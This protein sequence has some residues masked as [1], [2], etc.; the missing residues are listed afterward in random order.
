MSRHLGLK[1]GQQC[2][3]LVR[4]ERS[5]QVLGCYRSRHL[6]TDAIVQTPFDLSES[7]NDQNYSKSAFKTADSRFNLD[8]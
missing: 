3:T 7:R 8:M 1:R 4:N 2:S 6:R 5:R